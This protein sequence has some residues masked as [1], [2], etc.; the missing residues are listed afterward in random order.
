MDIKTTQWDLFMAKS[1]L[2]PVYVCARTHV[3]MCAGEG[4]SKG[5][6]CAVS[7]FHFSCD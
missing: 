1:L 3:R 2:C 6:L 5:T 7:L 4:Q